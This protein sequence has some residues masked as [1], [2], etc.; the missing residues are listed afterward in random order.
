MHGVIGQ[1]YMHSLLA[2]HTERPACSC[3]EAY[4]DLAQQTLRL[5][6][7]PAALDPDGSALSLEKLHSGREAPE[8]C[9]Q[10]HNLC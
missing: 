5:V 7:S 10:V 4:L 3:Q 8:G 6:A 9:L 1:R 2:V